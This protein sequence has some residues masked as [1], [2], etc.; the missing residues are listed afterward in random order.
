MVDEVLHE[1]SECKESEED[2]C[3]LFARSL[4][5]SEDSSSNARAEQHEQERDGKVWGFEF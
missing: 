1:A 2:V 4:Y 5:V 3:V